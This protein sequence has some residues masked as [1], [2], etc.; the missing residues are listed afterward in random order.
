MLPPK[1]FTLAVANL[2]AHKNKSQICYCDQ[3]SLQS[4]AFNCSFT[5]NLTPLGVSFILLAIVRFFIK[6]SLEYKIVESVKN[7]ICN[8][9]SYLTLY[10]PNSFFVVFR[11]MA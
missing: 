7:C 5:D 1:V 8:K 9:V 10:C 11:D 2:L 6:K 3:I 4:A